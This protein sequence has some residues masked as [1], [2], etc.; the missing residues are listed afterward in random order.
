MEWNRTR[1]YTCAQ[2]GAIG[3]EG[4]E[5]EGREQ[6]GE[7]GGQTR[8]DSKSFLRLRFE[9]QFL[10]RTSPL[11]PLALSILLTAHSLTRLRL[12]KHTSCTVED[13]KQY[14]RSTVLPLEK[15]FTNLKIYL[16]SLI[17]FVAM[18]LFRFFSHVRARVA[19]ILFV[20]NWHGRPPEAHSGVLTFALLFSQRMFQFH[21]LRLECSIFRQ[22]VRD[23]VVHTFCGGQR[24]RTSRKKDDGKKEERREIVRDTHYQLFPVASLKRDETLR[25]EKRKRRRL[26]VFRGGQLRKG[27]GVPMMTKGALSTLSTLSTLSLEVLSKSQLPRLKFFSSSFF[28]SLLCLSVPL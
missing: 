20:S 17:S 18:L 3:K 25:K 5:G 8:K 22:E 23:A 19:R 21:I 2:E 14:E 1:I 11:S 27:V 24:D 9:L 4:N 16:L 7:S 15:R 6:N 12:R 26:D 28:P 13:L 10:H